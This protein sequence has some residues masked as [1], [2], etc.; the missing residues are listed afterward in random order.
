MPSST[1]A[2][3]RL[4]P[5]PH[6]CK[7]ASMSRNGMKR[8]SSSVCRYWSPCPPASSQGCGLHRPA[9]R[10][11]GGLPDYCD[12]RLCPPSQ[13]ALGVSPAY[14]RSGA[15]HLCRSAGEPCPAYEGSHPRNR[16]GPK[17]SKGT[18]LGNS[19]YRNRNRRRFPARSP[20]AR[21]FRSPFPRG[22]LLGSGFRRRH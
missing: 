10:H 5:D 2:S 1:G 15:G 16:I 11:R 20:H 6:L 7:R 19:P 18:S 12:P 4:R 21:L 3:A 22:P 13:T 9:A 17:P 8:T 14:G